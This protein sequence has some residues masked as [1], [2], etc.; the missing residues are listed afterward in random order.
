MNSDI[1]TGGATAYNKALRVIVII[2]AV[3]GAIALLSFFGMGVMHRGMMGGV[4]G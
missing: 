1:D 4:M 3:I 2:L